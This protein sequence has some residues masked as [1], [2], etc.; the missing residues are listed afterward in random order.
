MSGE[1]SVAPA[2]LAACRRNLCKDRCSSRLL[3]NTE[4]GSRGPRSCQ[5]ST[6][7]RWAGTSATGTSAFTEKLLFDG[8][9]NA[10]A[11]RLDGRIVGAGVRPSREMSSSSCEDVGADAEARSNSR[12]HAS[13][14]GSLASA[15]SRGSLWRCRRLPPPPDE[16]GIRCCGRSRGCP[17]THSGARSRP[18]TKLVGLIKH[19]GM[20]Y[21]SGDEFLAPPRS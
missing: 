5:R 4:P 2:G 9:R 16:C 15:S 6:P 21:G 14:S 7:P 19:A 13:P 8:S 3:E 1:R 10:G 17:S 12:P 18:G 20:W 11:T